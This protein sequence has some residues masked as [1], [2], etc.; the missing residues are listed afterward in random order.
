MK[1]LNQNG[2]TMI[3]LIVV[4]S[5]LAIVLI[6]LASSM[7]SVV[8]AARQASYDSLVEEFK[9]AGEN[10]AARTSMTS[11][12]VR[13]LIENGLIETG[14]DGTVRDPR[15]ND[16]MN[17]YQVHSEFIRGSW[18]A[19]VIPQIHGN[20]TGHPTIPETMRPTITL[21]AT[22]RTITILCNPGYNIIVSS[23]RGFHRSFA[24]CANGSLIVSDVY[25][26]ERPTTFTV[27]ARS[28]D[29]PLEIRSRSTIW[30]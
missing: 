15:S 28:N 5:I 17:C 12:F 2:L 7:S 13:E 27:T 4:I 29:N 20:C 11:V 16:I 26:N 19:T 18:V 30:Q 3:E 6:I 23:N 8:T 14:L 10:Y 1:R 25:F 9:I 24:N 21:N 22:A